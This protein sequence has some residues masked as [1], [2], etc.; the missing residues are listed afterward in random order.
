MCRSA[1]GLDLGRELS[2]DELRR[3]PENAQRSDAR[4]PE[5]EESPVWHWSTWEEAAL[6][7]IRVS[8]SFTVDLTV[9]GILVI[10]LHYFFIDI[11]CLFSELCHF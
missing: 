7:D 9:H 1:H 4:K 3:L 6:P 5:T 8:D 11:E 10:A 2:G